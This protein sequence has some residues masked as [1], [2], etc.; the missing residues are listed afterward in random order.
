MDNQVLSAIQ[1]VKLNDASQWANWVNEIKRSAISRDVWDLC[2]PDKGA[3][4]V[5]K[6]MPMPKRP[7]RPPDEAAETAQK[8][9]QR[10][11]EEFRFDYGI[12]T[13]QKVNL[14]AVGD[15]I[16]HSLDPR[17]RDLL[18]DCF[19]P[20]E[21]L[22]ALKKQFSRGSAHKEDIWRKWV[23]FSCQKAGKDPLSWIEQWNFL[24]K[25]RKRIGHEIANKDAIR[26]FLESTRGLIPNWWQNA[27]EKW[28]AADIDDDVELL[29]DSFRLSYREE[30]KTKSSPS[31]PKVAFSTWQGH[32]EATPG[33]EPS[34]HPRA[35]TK[36]SYPQPIFKGPLSK[37]TCPCARTLPGHIAKTCFYL[38]PDLTP[39]FE[40]YQD[41]KNQ[42][43]ARLAKDPAW[44]A[45]IDEEIRSLSKEE[46]KSAGQHIAGYTNSRSKSTEHQCLTL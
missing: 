41:V 14:Q 20:Y 34:E 44:K 13:S 15:R 16:I 9:Y 22:V 6:R 33:D 7:V 4:E 18:N 40:L 24:R 21:L 32:E 17:Y 37:R 5:E 1:G 12:Y 2:D 3:D 31:M 29:I 27:Y 46:D 45:Y 42:V 8:K 35:A 19:S 28:V 36:K 38:R 30:P 23:A 43:A 39:R 11:L 25:E 26:Y 10:D